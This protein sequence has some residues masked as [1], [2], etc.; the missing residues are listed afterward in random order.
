[1]AYWGTDRV[2]PLASHIVFEVLQRSQSNARIEPDKGNALAAGLRKC[3][4]RRVRPDFFVRNIDLLVG[5]QRKSLTWLQSLASTSSLLYSIF[6]C[7]SEDVANP[8]GQGFMLA[9]L[10]CLLK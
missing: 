8:T 5:R 1:M 3:E 7:Y 4:L 10:R 9:R 2:I 6:G